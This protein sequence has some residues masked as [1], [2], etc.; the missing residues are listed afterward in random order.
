MD[1]WWENLEI[2]P[3]LNYTGKRYG[4]ALNKEWIGSFTVMNLN[5]NYYYK[6]YKFNIEAKNLFNKK[7]IGR[8]YTWDDSTG[9]TSYYASYPFT[10][11]AKVEVKFW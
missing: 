6:N 7:H 5:I 4:D 9:T 8:I 11:L 2:I 10:L 1:Y 3:E